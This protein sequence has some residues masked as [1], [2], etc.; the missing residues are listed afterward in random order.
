MDHCFLFSKHLDEKSCLCLKISQKGELTSPPAQ[1]SF[2]EIKTLQ[3][4]CTTVVIENANYA[5]LF[6]LELPWLPERKARTV[7]PYALE[8]KLTQPVEELHFAFD[9]W[10]Y[11]NHRYLLLRPN[12]IKFRI[13]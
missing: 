8:D 6:E 11:R 12:R 13:C 3:Q 10:R 1:R 5:T 2:A 7:I 4:G 9:K